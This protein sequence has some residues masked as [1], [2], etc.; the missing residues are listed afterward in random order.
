M[1][2][3]L[4]LAGRGEPPMKKKK[5][6]RFRVLSSFFLL[7]SQNYP[8]VNFLPLFVCVV[9][10]IYRQSGLVPKTHWSLNF[11]IFCQF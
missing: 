7:N 11:F 1:S 4:L 8:L 3:G 2:G 9:T 10:S 5:W 6:F